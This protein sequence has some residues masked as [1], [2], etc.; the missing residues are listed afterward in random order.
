M[1]CVRC[2]VA[3]CSQCM[4]CHVARY[5]HCMLCHVAHSARGAMFPDA[6]VA[7]GA[8]LLSAYSARGAMFQEAHSAYG[9]MLLSAYSA[10]GAIMPYYSQCMW[11]CRQQTRATQRCDTSTREGVTRGPPAPI[12]GAGT[13]TAS[14]PSF[15]VRCSWTHRQITTCTKLGHHHKCPFHICWR[16]R[17]QT[18]P[19]RQT[20]M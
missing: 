6:H 12:C 9:A 1:P 17:R 7:Y 3:Q 16:E 10:C 8:M 13:N 5:M 15:P 20:G 2:H 14:L 11:C 19:A 18:L 4:C